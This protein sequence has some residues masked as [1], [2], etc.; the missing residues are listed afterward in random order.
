[1][2]VPIFL[3]DEDAPT[4]QAMAS[5]LKGLGP[6]RCLSPAE[7]VEVIGAAGPCIVCLGP[8]SGSQ[9]VGSLAEAAPCSRRLA[10]VTDGSLSVLQHLLHEGG[11]TGVFAWP[12]EVEPMRD[13]LGKALAQ[14][15]RDERGREVFERFR[16]ALAGGDSIATIAETTAD[17]LYEVLDGAAVLVQVW[18]EDGLSADGV[19]LGGDSGRHWAEAVRGGEMSSELHSR[20]LFDGERSIGE[21]VIDRGAS[22]QPA[23]AGAGDLARIEP[24]ATTLAVAAGAQIRQREADRAVHALLVA[25]AGLAGCREHVGSRHVERI[26]RYVRLMAVGL[27]ADGHF[28][29]D[30][31][32]L[33]IEDMVRAVAL[34]DIGKLAVPD[35]ILLKPGQLSSQER[36][37]VETHAQ[38]GALAFEEAL[39]AGLAPRFLELSRDAARDHHERWD[40]SGYPRGL[41]GDHIPLV[42]RLLAVADTYDALTTRRPFRDGWSHA[43]AMTFLSHMSG[44]HFDPRVLES[45]LARASAVDALRDRL[46]DDEHEHELD[47]AWPAA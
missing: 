34:H 2:S 20:P 37:V 11:I 30:L 47:A 12:T 39:G 23:C 7:A 5:G 32:D 36:L 29:D 45:F 43:R 33:G 44:S 15:E 26:G 42:A 16:K 40:G 25:L 17:A 8:N 6:A 35:A 21:I 31:C 24:F 28:A 27:R 13:A 41:A 9:I 3:I 18:D 1:L 19:R 4:L 22:E 38:V 10:W 14:L 46:R